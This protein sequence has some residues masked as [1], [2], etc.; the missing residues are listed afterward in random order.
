MV[1]GK[2]WCALICMNGVE[3][4][5]AKHVSLGLVR[6]KK[7]TALNALVVGTIDCIE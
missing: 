5:T 4:L 6:V 7:L 1:H 3:L 2:V